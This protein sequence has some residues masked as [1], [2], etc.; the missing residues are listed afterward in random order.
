MNEAWVATSAERVHWKGCSESCPALAPVSSSVSSSLQAVTVI[1]RTASMVYV[2]CLNLILIVFKDYYSSSSSSSG[3][4]LRISFSSSMNDLWPG[5]S[6][7]M[8]I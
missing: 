4:S 2:S 1:V 3:S 6:S 7:M 8:S 5:T